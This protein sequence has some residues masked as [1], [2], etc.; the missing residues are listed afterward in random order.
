MK[1]ERLKTGVEQTF[2]GKMIEGLKS[3]AN[4]GQSRVFSN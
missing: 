3:A 4:N 2:A 1:N